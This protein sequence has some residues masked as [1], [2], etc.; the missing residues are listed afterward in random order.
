M[1]RFYLIILLVLLA[2]LFNCA[3]AT[4]AEPEKPEIET[5]EIKDIRGIAPKGTPQFD[6]TTTFPE[7]KEDALLSV[8]KGAAA[9]FANQFYISTTD[10]VLINQL[11][12]NQT[13][14]NYD[15]ERRVRIFGEILIEDQPVGHENYLA[16]IIK[17]LKAFYDYYLYQKN[18]TD[19]TGHLLA[20]TYFN[21]SAEAVNNIKYAALGGHIKAEIF[22]DMLLEEE[23]S[24]VKTVT[25]DYDLNSTLRLDLVLSGPDGGKLVTTMCLDESGETSLTSTGDL[26]NLI[27]ALNPSFEIEVFDNRNN[28]VKT[29]SYTKEDLARYIAENTYQIYEILNN[30]V[31]QP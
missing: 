4:I 15:E 22:F 27:Y 18:S 6:E 31:P 1:K 3:P 20:S 7:T 10:P 23:T 11:T 5:V 30:V 14:K 17:K 12:G 8:I 28:S 21:L 29:F 19:V 24:I 13:I 2:G 9:T 16:G 25:A 26:P